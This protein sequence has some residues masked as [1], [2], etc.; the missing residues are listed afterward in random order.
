MSY[1]IQLDNFAG[2][3][4][5]L[6]FFI[7]RDEID[8]MDIPIATVTEEYLT[9]LEMLQTL[10]VS[11]AGDFM[12]M[13]A[14]LMRI[15]V[16]MLLPS[17]S[18]E[19]DE[20][21]EDP[22]TALVHQ[23]LEYQRY[24]KAAGNLSAM[25]DLESRRFHPSV[26]RNVSDTEEDP[27]FYLEDVTLFELVTLFKKVLKQIPP[28]VHY[29]VEREE[30]QVKERVAMILSKFVEKSQIMFSELFSNFSSRQDIIVTFVAILEL[31]RDG[32]VRVTQKK[33]FEDILLERVEA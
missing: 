18:E 29:D 6:L 20:E 10:N 2:P 31:I 30:I 8:I 9:Y 15:K 17:L 33:L 22:R 21:F 4:D 19:D 25:N 3:L 26:I 1:Q 16:K 11:L 27:G 24:K 14:T 28:A 23:L 13:A 12:V 5:L 7:R 32:Q